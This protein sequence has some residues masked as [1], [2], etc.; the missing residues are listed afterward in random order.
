MGVGGGGGVGG[1]KDTKI[2]VS[3]ENR[4]W[5]RKLSHHSCWGLLIMSLALYHWAIPTPR[6]ITAS[7][8]GSDLTQRT[9]KM[10]RPIN[11]TGTLIFTLRTFWGQL[12][13][14]SCTSHWT[15]MYQLQPS[16]HTWHLFSIPPGHKTWPLHL[17]SALL[18]LKHKQ[19]LVLS[20][21]MQT[22][23]ILKMNPINRFHSGT[24][25]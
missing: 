4:S 24:E 10:E 6:T 23:S 25:T 17:D 1:G 15:E 3:T 7:S 20:W 16:F 9:V 22:V 2:R 5:R 11:I 12:N 8:A 19:T 21:N 13:Q 18:A 14:T